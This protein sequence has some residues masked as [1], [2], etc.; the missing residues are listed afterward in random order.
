[1]KTGNIRIVE[2]NENNFYIEFE[3]VNLFG[4]LKW[5][6]Y[7]TVHKNI[8]FASIVYFETFIKASAYIKCKIRKEKKY[9]KYYYVK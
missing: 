4:R 5:R 3:H 6:A 7:K 8:D 2:V 1:M 9:Q